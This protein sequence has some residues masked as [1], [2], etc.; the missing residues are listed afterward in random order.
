MP[1]VLPDAPLP[2]AA[3]WGD[4]AVIVPWVLY[5]RYG[6]AGILAAQF[7]E[8]ARPG[9]TSSPGWPATERLW[10]DGFQFGDWL[11]PTRRRTS[12]AQ[13]R[14]DPHLVA[15]A[16]FARSA[17]LRRPGRRRARAAR[18]RGPLPARS[19]PRSAQAFADEYVTPAGRLLSDAATAYAL[20]IEF[21]LLPDAE[22]R[23]HAGRPAGRSWC[24][25]AATA[26]AP[27]SSARR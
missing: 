3:A 18:G 5:Q 17:E 23:Q 20:A 25:T 2:A 6:D 22:Q 14:T 11:D 16:Y 12:R 27:A 1:N 9:S 26:S 21:D 13:A 15:T 19:P 4:A 24:A 10:D 7:D 8:H